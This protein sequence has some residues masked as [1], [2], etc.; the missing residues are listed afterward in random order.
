MGPAVG[1]DDEDRP[2]HAGLVDTRPG[3]VRAPQRGGGRPGPAERDGLLDRQRVALDEERPGRKVDDLPC[4]TTIQCRLDARGCV[5]GPVSIRGRLDRRGDGPAA[6]DPADS[7]QAGDPRG[8]PVGRKECG[9]RHLSRWPCKGTNVLVRNDHFVQIERAAL[10]GRATREIAQEEL[11]I[12][13]GCRK[14]IGENC[15]ALDTIHPAFHGR[16]GGKRAQMHLDAMPLI[17]GKRRLGSKSGRPPPISCQLQFHP[18]THQRHAGK[19]GSIIVSSISPCDE[20]HEANHGIGSPE[21]DWKECIE[22]NVDISRRKRG[23]ETLCQIG[24]VRSPAGT[25]HLEAFL[26]PCGSIRADAQTIAG[27]LPLYVTP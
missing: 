18:L 21:T 5:L 15:A 14:V 7:H 27:R 19:V 11:V 10:I 2:G 16:A 1:P 8:G 22:T 6:G 24:S 13:R 17:F 4:G 3:A 25:N 12:G 20:G 9:D 26:T 23:T